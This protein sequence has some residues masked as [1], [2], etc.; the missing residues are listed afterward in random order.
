MGEKITVEQRRKN[1]QAIRSQSKLENSVTKAIWA[2]GIRFRKNNKSLFGKPDISIKKY[3]IVIFI[4]SC[5]WHACSLHGNRPKNNSEYWDKKLDRNI[6]RDIKVN[7]Y[8]SDLNW[9][10]LRIWEHE[11]KEDFN[12]TINK[13]IDFINAIKEKSV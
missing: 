2:K 5:F 6:A 12:G 3:K 9:A 7:N 4:D 8:Y 1:M 11:L 10:I 13:I